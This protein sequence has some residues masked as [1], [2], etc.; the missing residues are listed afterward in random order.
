MNIPSLG[1]LEEVG[2]RTAWAH[3]AANFTPWLA[4]NLDRLGEAMGI[5]LELVQSEV[6][7][8]T[9]SADILARNPANDSLILIENQLEA[10]D[11]GHLGQIMTYLAGLGAHTIIWIAPE[12]RDAHLSAIRWLNEHTVD[13]FSFFAVRLRLVRI[14]A[15]DMAPIFEIVERPNDWDRQLQQQARGTSEMSERGLFRKSFWTAFLARHPSE[16]S[17]GPANADASRW[18]KLPAQKLV[19]A[20]YVSKDSV[21]V[22][23]RGERGVASDVTRERIEPFASTLETA[24]GAAFNPSA[25]NF[26]FERKRA[27]QTIDQATWPELMDWLHETTDSYAK[28]IVEIMGDIS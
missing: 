1:R 14:G 9:F 21:G 17:A 20:Q 15:S 12:F 13:P 6:A 4:Q 28:K 22:F 18:R 10:S 5:P 26:F 16:I 25:E 3:E 8:T 11:H 19:I 2:V 24:L 27:G 7:I 23:V